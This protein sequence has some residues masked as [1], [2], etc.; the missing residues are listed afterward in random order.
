MESQAGLTLFLSP[1]IIKLNNIIFVLRVRGKTTLR[2]SMIRN[3]P[4]NLI[5]VILA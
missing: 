5:Q 4:L 3:K 2:C 1:S